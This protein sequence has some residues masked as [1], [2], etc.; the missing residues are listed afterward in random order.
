MALRLAFI[1]VLDTH[2]DGPGS[3]RAAFG[4]AVVVGGGISG[5]E[6]RWWLTH[7]LQITKRFVCARIFLNCFL[8]NAFLALST[9]HSLQAHEEKAGCDD[10]AHELTKS[11][12]ISKCVG[13]QSAD[14]KVNLLGTLL[15]VPGSNNGLRLSIC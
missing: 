3:A 4:A 12:S 9:P 6:W 5:V 11:A 14:L 2:A 1:D 10:H 13:G 7:S 8:E 15:P